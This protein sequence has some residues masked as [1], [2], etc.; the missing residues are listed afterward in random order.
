[1]RKISLGLYLHLFETATPLESN[2]F[3]VPVIE[4]YATELLNWFS[5]V[6]KQIDP[7]S[8]KLKKLGPLIDV[9][10]IEHIKD[11]KEHL[12][13]VAD[14]M[15]ERLLCLSPFVKLKPVLT[16]DLVDLE[17]DVTPV[18]LRIINIIV[19]I[20]TFGVKKHVF[21]PIIEKSTFPGRRRLVFEEIK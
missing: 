18:H 15:S 6:E 2:R 17:F 8:Y 9:M 5:D 20:L 12:V 1:M 3:L 4:P 16:R 7:T 19:G 13:F 10:P 21:E 11:E 14:W